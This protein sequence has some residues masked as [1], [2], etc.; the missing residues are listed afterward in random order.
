MA[1]PRLC[2]IGFNY[3]QPFLIQRAITLLSE[4]RSTQSD[5]NGYGLIGAAFFV[6]VGIAISTV[7]YQHRFYRVITMF[8]GAMV[9]LIYDHSL[10]LPDGACPESSAITLMSTDVE[11][12]IE[13][14]QEVNEIWARLIEVAIGVWLLARQ[15]GAPCVVPIILVVVCTAGQSWVSSRIGG[16]I[17]NWNEAIEKRVSVTSSFLNSIKAVK[18][19]GLSDVL[20]KSVQALR[21]HEL[22]LCMFFM[23]NILYLN[24]IGKYAR[25]EGEADTDTIQRLFR[26]LG[27]P[28]LPSLPSLSRPESEENLRLEQPKRSLHSQLSRW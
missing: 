12:I 16:S 4:L 7:H 1:I 27:L 2:L 28:F 13:A 17:K 6:Y 9:G 25:T 18:M 21:I 10:A 15:V 14:L 19:M 24:L 5:N 26:R 20:A 3:A 22:Y 8:R 23:R 11:S